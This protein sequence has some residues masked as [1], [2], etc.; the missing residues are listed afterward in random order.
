MWSD[1][2]K[3]Y[4]DRVRQV[5]GITSIHLT[6]KEGLNNPYSTIMTHILNNYSDIETVLD[7][8]AGDGAVSL[9]SSKIKCDKKL[10]LCDNENG[11]LKVAKHNADNL[12]IKNIYFIQGNILK[13]PFRDNSFDLVWSAGVNEHF[14]GEE[15]RQKT[16][17]EMVR[18]SN[19][20]VG[21]IVPNALS[22]PYRI[23]KMISRIFNKW[24]WGYEKPL[25]R[26]ELE[27]RLQKEMLR[28]NSRYGMD[29]L[30]SLKFLFFRKIFRRFSRK[31]FD[32]RIHHLLNIWLGR[33]IGVL[34]EKISRH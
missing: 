11:A 14:E 9:I 31:A 12:K 23:G 20:Y 17:S 24:V 2:W 7:I 25:S 32:Y 30:F 13:I 21:I 34:A 26:L 1:Y 8:G 29:I 19:K 5:R 22:I 27:Q 16:F 6:E 4:L 15:N 10:I 28:I 3:D 33:D 18:V